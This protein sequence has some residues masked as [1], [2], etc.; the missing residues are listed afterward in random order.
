[1]EAVHRFEGTVNQVLGDGIMPSFGAPIAHETTPWRACYA[2][3]A[4][5][6]PCGTTPRRCGAPGGWTAHSRRPQ[7]REVVVRT[8][9][10]DLHMDLL[11][12]RPDHAPGGA[13]GATG[14]T[15]DG[16]A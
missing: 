1:M 16:P 12:D 13:H 8:I 11:A 3:L 7:R 10:N 5:R 6:P 14:H 2:A 4:S 15:G 9:G